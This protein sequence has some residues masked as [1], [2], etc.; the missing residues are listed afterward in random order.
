MQKVVQPLD[1]VIRLRKKEVQLPE[2]QIKKSQA[3]ADRLSDDYG[4]KKLRPAGVSRAC[5]GSVG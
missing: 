5:P 1:E 4:K 3:A 2:M